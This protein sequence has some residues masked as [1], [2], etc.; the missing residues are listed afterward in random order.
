MQGQAIEAGEEVLDEGSHCINVQA[1]Y[2]T[3]K[4]HQLYDKL[5]Y[6]RQALG[7]I[8]NSP[9]PDKRVG[10]PVQFTRCF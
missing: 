8:Q 2:A 9:K 4:L 7:S 10:G 3:N 1:S 5:E 6:K